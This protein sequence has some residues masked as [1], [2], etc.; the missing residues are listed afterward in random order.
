MTDP[1]LVHEFERRLQAGHTALAQ[2]AFDQALGHYEAAHIL[3]QAHTWRHIRSHVALF[4]WGWAQGNGRELVGQVGRLV[5]ATLFTWAWV[6]RGNPGS[7]RVGAFSPHPIPA[8]LEAWL[9]GPSR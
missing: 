6:P 9:S 3:G 2:R 1:A 8:D 7:T 4:R 5:G